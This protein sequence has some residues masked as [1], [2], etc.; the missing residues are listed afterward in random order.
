M[1]QAK[2]RGT[3]QE[4][5]VLAIEKAGIEREE[6]KRLKAAELAAMTEEQRQKRR[7]AEIA[8]V[9]LMSACLSMGHLPYITRRY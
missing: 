7:D 4:R 1:G 6:Y 5:R 9:Q 2:R 8:W 3:Y